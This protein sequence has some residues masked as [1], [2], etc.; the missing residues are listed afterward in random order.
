MFKGDKT[1]H[2]LKNM[3][4]TKSKVFLDEEMVK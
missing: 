4:K 1:T 3:G 2:I